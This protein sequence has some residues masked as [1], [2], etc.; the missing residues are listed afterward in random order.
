MSSSSRIILKGPTAN[1]TCFEWLEYKT[2]NFTSFTWEKDAVSG[3]WVEKDPKFP[4]R[5]F[6]FKNQTLFHHH[7]YRMYFTDQGFNFFQKN[8]DANPDPDV[9]L[10]AL[11]KMRDT[12]TTNLN[13]GWDVGHLAEEY[14]VL[15]IKH[16]L[17]VNEM[18]VSSP[19]VLTVVGNPK[20]E[21]FPPEVL[22]KVSN[23]TND[24]EIFSQLLSLPLDTIQ[25]F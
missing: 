1:S 6:V 18:Y 4:A 14:I 17:K 15:A 12:L 24:E 13:S 25:S 16:N 5:K 2:E 19:L 21:M 22:I 23:M 9:C 7:A 3:A 10:D 20:Y 8:F 11:E